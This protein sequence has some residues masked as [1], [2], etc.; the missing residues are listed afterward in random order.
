MTLPLGLTCLMLLGCSADDGG[1]PQA[2]G[3]SA[4]SAD[5]VEQPSDEVAEGRR[6]TLDVGHCYVE[7]IRVGNKIWVT[8]RTLFG[9]G[10]G[11]PRRF[12]P[13]GTFVVTSA[14]EATF[15]AD[16][17]AEVRFKVAPKPLPVRGCR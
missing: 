8:R 11:I 14:T 16:G 15:I 6:V 3:S 9:Y 5:G 12:T 1:A 2:E 7:P 17:G 10:G 13:E 4:S